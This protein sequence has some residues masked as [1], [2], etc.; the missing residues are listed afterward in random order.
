M[1]LLG[2]SRAAG[3]G[4]PLRVLEVERMLESL[5]A[6]VNSERATLFGHN[7]V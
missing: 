4:V 3:Q 5:K 6:L 1:Y 7:N 2:D